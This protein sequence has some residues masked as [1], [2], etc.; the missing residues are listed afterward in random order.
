MVVGAAEAEVWLFPAEG[1]RFLIGQCSLL[2]TSISNAE[3]SVRQAR[4]YPLAG[5]H[6]LLCTLINFSKTASLQTA[7][8]TGQST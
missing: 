3:T 7:T 5:Q 2:S 4:G 1:R 6:V 8:I